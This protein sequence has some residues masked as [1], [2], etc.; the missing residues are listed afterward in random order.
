MTEKCAAAYLPR[1]S[2]TAPRGRLFSVFLNLIHPR[3][4]LNQNPTLYSSFLYFLTCGHTAVH[5]K[6]DVPTFP[7]SFPDNRQAFCVSGIVHVT[8]VCPIKLKLQMNRSVQR[9]CCPCSWDSADSLVCSLKRQSEFLS[10][11]SGLVYSNIFIWFKRFISIL[12]SQSVGC[13]W[14]VEHQHTFV[15]SYYSHRQLRF[16]HWP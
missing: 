4:R 11:P 8:V 15:D 12:K 7:E 2:D 6:R 13:P 10:P 9:C 16:V 5:S 14:Q 1:S 3:Q